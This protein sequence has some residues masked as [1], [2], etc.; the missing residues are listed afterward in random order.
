MANKVNQS[1]AI[2]FPVN[3]TSLPGIADFIISLVRTLV[4]EFRD[5]ALRLNKAMVNDGTEAP[6]APIIYKPYVKAALPDVTGYVDGMIIVTDDVGGRVPAF[7]DG[8]NWRRVT[9]RA[10]IS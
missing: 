4:S 1:P 10:V 5:H 9:D 7:S 2:S 3:L 6:S 8:T